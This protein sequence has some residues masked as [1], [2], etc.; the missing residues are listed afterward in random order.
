M[1]SIE[2]FTNNDYFVTTNQIKSLNV[3]DRLHYN[4]NDV[5]VDDDNILL[6]KGNLLYP[7]MKLSDILDK[8]KK[9]EIKSLIDLE[10]DFVI[11]YYNK[12]EKLMYII[13]DKLALEPLYYYI[14]DRNVVLSTNFWD[15][16]EFCDFDINDIDVQALKEMVLFLKPLSNRTFFKKIN[17]FPA[18][19]IGIID[20]ENMEMTIEEYWDF[21]FNY[22]CDLTIEEASERLDA[23]INHA[24]QGMIKS[25]PESVTYGVGV[26]GGLDTR[27]IPHYLL[28]NNVKKLKSF[29]I[30]KEKPR[31]HFLSRDHK[32]AHDITEYYG[33]EHHISE[34][35]TEDYKKKIFHDVKSHPLRASNI[36]KVIVKNLPDFDILVTGGYG[37]VV[38]GH[39]ISKELDE[40]SDNELVDTIVSTLSRI[41]P[42]PKRTVRSIIASIVNNIIHPPSINKRTL[43]RNY[44]KGIITEDELNIVKKKLCNYIMKEKNKGKTNSD[45]FMKYHL[46]LSSKY[47]A[48]EGLS[49]TKKSYSI[50]FPYTLEEVVNWH[51]DFVIGRKVL[52]Y[53][54]CQKIPAMAKIP[55]QNKHITIYD[56]FSQTNQLKLFYLRLMSYLTYYVRGSGLRYDVWIKKKSFKDFA[57]DVLMQDNYLFNKIFDVEYLLDNLDNIHELVFEN[58][59]K[60]KYFLDVIALKEY[61]K[62]C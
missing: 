22:E 14:D 58:I 61:R 45:V 12:K 13:N 32:N 29:I 46:L 8:I 21:R 37:T 59:I 40:L 35:D 11:T 9:S 15:I 30:G 51:P 43:K 26:S 25:N 55:G 44:I 41:N 42:S 3:F 56:K 57:L 60:T 28:K 7:S 16:V 53:V 24:V 5:Y 27:I 50:Y 2:L 20:L 19:S 34:Y 33:I 47:G 52:E 31:R 62:W 10:G 18:A 23:A 39:I 49:G 1:N 38:G 6:L 4:G 54:I 17:F 36:L 48:F